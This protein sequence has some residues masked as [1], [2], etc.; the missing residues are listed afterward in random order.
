M[1]R[2]FSGLE[3]YSFSVWQLC[4][5]WLLLLVLVIYECRYSTCTLLHYYILP[6]EVI[7]VNSSSGGFLTALRDHGLVVISISTI[8]LQTTQIINNEQG[9]IFVFPA[10]EPLR[11][12]R[13]GRFVSFFSSPFFFF[14]L[15]LL[16]FIFASSWSC[17]A[18]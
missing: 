7:I 4:G 1:S 8:K 3:H 9:Y 17:W 5:C 13:A 15:L 12:C 18:R 16:A 11:R 2:L 6:Q 10:A 14:F